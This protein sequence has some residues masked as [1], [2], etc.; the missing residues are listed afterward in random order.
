MLGY[1]IGMFTQPV[2][3]PFDLNDDSVMQQAVEQH[4][5]H[6]RVAEQLSPLGEA[7]IGGEDRGAC[8]VSGVDQ[9]EKQVRAAA[10]DGDI[11]DFVDDEQRGPG[12]EADLLGQAILSLGF[13]L[14]SDEFGDRV[15]RQLAAKLGAQGKRC[16][17]YLC[18]PQE[19]GDRHR[20]GSRE[21]GS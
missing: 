20:A 7:A 4:G 21:S 8:F 15:E 18:L 2:V 9:L 12:I 19:D 14:R 13:V 16:G 10:V 11:S 6:D 17:G 5:G 3:G 1:Q